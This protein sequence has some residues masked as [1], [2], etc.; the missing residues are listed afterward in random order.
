VKRQVLIGL[1][2]A[3]AILLGVAALGSTTST[4]QHVWRHSAGGGDTGHAS[5]DLN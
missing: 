2:A 1:C 5:V 3:L 4:A